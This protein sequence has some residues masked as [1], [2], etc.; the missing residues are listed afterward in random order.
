MIID[1]VARNSTDNAPG[2]LK[3][4]PT[5]HPGRTIPKP[6]KRRIKTLSWSLPV[7]E[8]A[9]AKVRCWYSRDVWLEQL[10]AHL[11]SDEGVSVRGEFRMTV[12][13]VM[14]VARA[15]AQCAEGRTGRNVTTSHET[16]GNT[17][18]R[19]GKTVQ[20]ARSIM[21]KLGYANV[22][23]NGR[24]LTTEERAQAFD[25]HGG[26][27]IRAA[28]VRALTVPENAP[29][30]QN[31]QLPRKGL[32]TTDLHSHN[33]SPTRAQARKAA[34][35]PKS[36]TKKISGCKKPQ[37]PFSPGLFVVAN[38]LVQRLPFL[39]RWRS[40]VTETPGQKPQIRHEGEHLGSVCRV[41][42]NTGIDISRLSGR[43]IIEVIDRLTA[44]SGLQVMAGDSVQ[45]PLGYLTTLL[46]RVAAYIEYTNYRTAA[47][48]QTMQAERRAQLAAEYAERE[49]ER[50]AERAIKND[51]VNIAAAAEFFAA[52][53]ARRN[54][55]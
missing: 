33:Y 35:R 8:G 7:P 53:A 36:F 3:R 54:A 13:T 12:K 19:S 24:Y 46:R 29:Q 10:E 49:A 15:D 4:V 6:K 14:Q 17:I 47:E 27:Q 16:V 9:Y 37:R 1:I 30:V 51:P 23:V 39:I 28:S 25:A 22:L 26:K 34:S 48:R 45:N 55:E 5:T 21:V 41:I 20:R 52:L 50:E 40:L 18:G 31:V 43:D 11:C 32:R 38:E 42:A 2:R 44:D